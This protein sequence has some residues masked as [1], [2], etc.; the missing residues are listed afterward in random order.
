MEF[1]K[2]LQELR[3]QKGL[4]QEELA[5]AL[6]VSRTAVSKWESGR[7]YPNID[8][9]RAI[10]QFFGIT[11]DALL[12]GEQ[13]LE[14]AEADAK[15]KQRHLQDLVFGLLDL[16]AAAF[17]FLPFFKQS[18]S[19]II[20]AVSLL[21]ANALSPWLNIAYTIIVSAML[22]WGIATLALQNCA[23]PFWVRH[24]RNVSLALNAIGLLLFVIST[25]PYA[26]VFTFIFLTIKVFLLIKKQ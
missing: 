21:A 12:S 13:L 6:F 7:G 22:L 18:E 4:T 1:H 19:G 14:I 17:F 15:Q 11:V 26:A 8:S 23:L 9:L 16:S 5:T 10:A 3:K 20:K 25:Q 24:R 2:N